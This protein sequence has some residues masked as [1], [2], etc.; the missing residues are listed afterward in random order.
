M[1]GF[2]IAGICLLV[3]LVAGGVGGLWLGMHIGEAK[4]AATSAAGRA[5]TLPAGAEAALNARIDGLGTKIDAGLHAI[6]TKVTD[7]IAAIPGPTKPAA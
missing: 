2:E 5:T 4:A 6:G 7:A 1:T 3:G